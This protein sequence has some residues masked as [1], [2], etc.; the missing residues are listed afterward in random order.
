MFFSTPI[1]FG[2]TVVKW[3][4]MVHFKNLDISILVAAF[5]LFHFQIF[6]DFKLRNGPCYNLVFYAFKMT[7]I[8]QG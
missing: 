5:I 2:C 7:F 3:T 4:L 6:V 1:F 8:F